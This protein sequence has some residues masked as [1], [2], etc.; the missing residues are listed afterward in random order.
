MRYA[1]KLEKVTEPACISC[2]AAVLPK[3]C[4]R[5]RQAKNRPAGSARERDRLHAMV[6][7]VFA[8][9]TLIRYIETGRVTLRLL[10]LKV[11]PLVP[12]ILPDTNYRAMADIQ[13]EAHRKDERSPRE[14]LSD[15]AYFHNYIASVHPQ[16]H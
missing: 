14:S 12:C 11:V 15:T 6:G 7:C 8:G 9:A 16:N 3:D 5:E 1:A 13:V 10:N 4:G 2:R